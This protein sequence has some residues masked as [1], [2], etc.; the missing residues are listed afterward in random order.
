MRGRGRGSKGGRGRGRGRFTQNE[1]VH[2]NV[3]AIV[4]G[5]SQG[6]A[7][8]QRKGVGKVNG[9]VS[10]HS[11]RQPY[12]KYVQN[13]HPQQYRQQTYP[14]HP[15]TVSTNH[16][17]SHPKNQH[18]K[19]QKVTQQE[20]MPIHP[21]KKEHTQDH[22][23]KNSSQETYNSKSKSS[24]PKNSNT[25]LQGYWL[26][27]HLKKHN[28]L[29]RTKDNA[30]NTQ[31]NAR[32]ADCSHSQNSS[33]DI[34]Q[35]SNNLRNTEAD[36]QKN[37]QYTKL[38]IEIVA[39]PVS[40][41]PSGG[42]VQET[43]HS[44]SHKDVVQSGTSKRG[45]IASD[46][47][48]LNQ[49]LSDI[50]A[51][52]HR[53]QFGVYNK[54]ET[55]TK[56][57]NISPQHIRKIE[58]S[59][60]SAGKSQD[61]ANEHGSGSQSSVSFIDQASKSQTV[62]YMH[63]YP[64][65]FESLE[66]PLISHQPIFI[67][68][69]PGQ[70]LPSVY[71]PQ[72]SHPQSR[73]DSSMKV[74]NIEMNSGMPHLQQSPYSYYSGGMYGSHL[75]P[76]QQPFPYNPLPLDHNVP[77]PDMR[78]SSLRYHMPEQQLHPFHPQG[79]HQLSSGHGSQHQDFQGGGLNDSPTDGSGHLGGSGSNSIQ[80]ENSKFPLPQS[81]SHGEVNGMKNMTSL[82]PH[83]FNHEGPQISSQIAPHHQQNFPHPYMF[84][85]QYIPYSNLVPIRGPGYYKGAPSTSFT[86]SGVEMH[87][88]H[89]NASH[90]LMAST[91][92]EISA[93]QKHK[94]PID[95]PHKSGPQDTSSF[96]KDRSPPSSSQL[97]QQKQGHIQSE[98]HE[99]QGH[100]FPLLQNVA[101]FFSV[102]NST[103]F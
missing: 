7:S 94:M 88:S 84:Q 43:L 74:N 46:P 1:Y 36:P 3:P 65:V 102:F 81:A 24:S 49:M 77:I 64:P 41:K 6:Q 18:Q 91:E 19:E 11:Y 57:V 100:F 9:D 97:Q 28:P 90:T 70:Q 5:P 21:E 89:S 86:P 80:S 92:G 82:V 25:N 56:A 45:P 61:L 50:D 33:R 17:P 85:H 87:N 12:R 20:Q 23:G 78:M 10:A 59:D 32:G 44:E 42:K 71:L 48:F 83:S 47:V 55:P 101:P 31:S 54:D 13:G 66:D 96:D 63:H 73:Q 51:N 68:P 75:V 76:E 14:Y 72:P 69:Y 27:N 34:V 15:N 40:K 93:Q 26:Q 95:Y 79:G 35:N 99:N 22:V 60:P 8:G 67:Q 103:H 29:V 98:M 30:P 39:N 37:S 38:K 62:P 58:I 4:Q 16:F 2:E 52:S 53:F